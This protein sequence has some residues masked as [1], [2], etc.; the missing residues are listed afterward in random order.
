MNQVSYCGNKAVADG[1]LLSLLS[2]RENSAEPL[3]V[4][5]VT[6]N[7]TSLSPAYRPL[8]EKD[9]AFFEGILREKNP[10]SQVILLD[11]TAIFLKEFAH[12]PNLDTIYTPYS[13][14]RMIFDLETRLPKRLLYLDADTV[15]ERDPS[16]LFRLDLEG[17]D[18]AM[19]PDAVF[20]KFFD[21]HY[22]NSGV[23]LFDLEAIRKD[24]LLKEGRH[25][26]NTHKFTMPD[27]EALNRCQKEKILL[28]PRIYNEQ[29]ELSQET[30]I[31]HYCQQ[32]RA[33]PLMHIEKS[34][35]WEGEKFAKGYP[36]EPHPELLKL[37]AE[38]KKAME[39]K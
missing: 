36:N 33:L 14:L 13:M 28:L 39:A 5:L 21:P 22:C 11:E 27:Q 8:E 3:C 32:I 16:T 4:Y 25:L 10:E 2:Y 29:R 31:R 23:I 20:S 35:P 1:L 9:R 38:K 37:F 18:R 17:C 12:S 26:L 30:I 34:K 7:F 24:G 19:V 6:A 15:I